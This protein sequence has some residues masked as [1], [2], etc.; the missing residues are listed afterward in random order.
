MSATSAGKPRLVIAVNPAPRPLSRPARD[1]L[2]LREPGVAVAP[3]AAS[4]AA[5]CPWQRCL[6]HQIS[7]DPE[8]S[9]RASA[10]D[11]FGNPVRQLAIEFPHDSLS[12]RAESTIEVL[13]HLPAGAEAALTSRRLGRRS[14]PGYL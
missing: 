8:P 3:A 2:Q 14:S 6:A 10:F 5:R 9:P 7:V 4:D 13:P 11:C 12:V 1:E